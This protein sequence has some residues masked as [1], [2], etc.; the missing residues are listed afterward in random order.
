[1]SAAQ[2][3][4][5]DGPLA[6]ALA[7]YEARPSQLRMA[8]AVEAALA[9]DGVLLA[10]AGTGTGKTLAYLVPALAS[11]RKVV[12]STGTRALQDQIMDHDLPLLERALGKT[13]DAACMK[14]L[15]NYLCLRRYHAFM[16]GAA[17][18]SGKYGPKLDVLSAW[19]ERTESG[20][21]AELESVP[22]GS[23][24]WAEVHSGSDTRVGSKCQYYD[25][26]Y[27][28]RMRNR[29]REASLVVV[30]HHLFFADL[31]LRE[32]AFAASV[33]PDY[34][35]VVFD[36]AHLLEDIATDFFGV[37]VS[38]A[39]LE[40]LVRDAERVLSASS[41]LLTSR[42]VL[43][44]LI[45]AAGA[46]FAALPRPAAG[47]GGRV[48]LP[49][50]TF[51]GRVEAP[52]FG[53][54]AALEALSELCKGHLE[55]GQGVAQLA[56]RGQALRDDI[57]AVAEGGRGQDVTWTA[58]R[59]RG[60]VIGTSPIDIGP[61]LGERLFARSQ[62]T[63]L[64]SA[65]L[66]T[67]GNFDFIKSRLGIDFEV[68]EEL[69]PSPFDYDTQAAMYL[70]EDLPDPRTDGFVERAAEQIVALCRLTGGGAFVLCTS[71]R[72]MRALCKRC[73]P[74]LHTP[75]YMQ[76]EAPHASILDRF[77]RDGDAVL[78]ATATFWQ[79]VDVPGDALRL[80][81]IDKL[82]FDVPSDPLVQARCR[83]LQAE[84]QAPFVKYLVPAAALTLKQGFGRLIRKRTDRGVV[85]ILDRRLTAKGYG[86][87]FLRSLPAA[88]RCRTF[89]EVEAFWKE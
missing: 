4:G 70:P 61:V 26:C 78:F 24:L 38:S 80:V 58:Q 60:V 25:A 36:E 51:T 85:A 12:V 82:P 27:V 14:G 10:E 72:A 89:D 68:D 30:N 48:P 5:P 29:A 42:P 59:G 33:I 55:E 56:R 75:V 73:R 39:K 31:A 7:G 6:K 83:R 41:L 21:R 46:F 47:E 65:T 35:A 69:L 15:S 50:E 8:G 71:L 34:E 64:T 45:A 86:K 11:G 88:R 49:P 52:L 57:M 81:V 76:G 22:E 28:T 20:D 23:P 2:F 16:Q 77:R 74:Q 84:G 67:G 44:N 87:L 19:Q 53:L 32:G 3:L 54:D 62:A 63:I 43:D 66:S 13:V 17:A 40:T 37:S 1:M 9:H 18:G 79:G